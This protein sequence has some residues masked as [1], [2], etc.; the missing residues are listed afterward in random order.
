MNINGIGFLNFIS[1]HILFATVIM[2]KN[3]K[4]KD[5]EGGIK[6]F[7]KLYLQRGFKITRI[8]SYSEFETLRAKM[9][10]IGISLD[11]TSKKEHVTDIEQLNQTVKERVRSTQVAMPFKRFSK[12]IIIHIIV[13]AV[14]WL[15]DYPP[16]KP[17]SGLT[18]TKVPVKL[19][20]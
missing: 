19:F 9:D 6:Q 2:I 18:N 1:R 4:I 8:H 15:N 20:I 3:K 5:I 17:A 12:L 13:T 16:S 7:N 14:F 10:Y 11:C